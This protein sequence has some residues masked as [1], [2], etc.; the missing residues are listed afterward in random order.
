MKI[1]RKVSTKKHLK[2][3]VFAIVLSLAILCSANICQTEAISA[4]QSEQ[5]S[6][7]A[8]IQETADGLRGLVDSSETYVLLDEEML[9]AGSSVSD[10]IAMALAFSGEEE[11]YDVYLERLEQ[12]VTVAYEEQNCLD[13]VEATPYHR[14]TLTVLALGG[15]PLAFGTDANQEN[16]NL[17]ADGT[18]YFKGDSLG[19]QGLS[20]YI[21]ALLA[22]DAMAYEVPEDATYTRENIIAEILKAQSAEG[23]FSQNGYGADVDITAMAL[24]ALAPYQDRKEVNSAIEKALDYLSEEMTPYGTFVSGSAESCES[25]AQVIL[26]M[27]ALDLDVETDV[28]FQKNGMTP[29]EGIKVFRL[30]D[31]TYVHTLEEEEGNLIATEQALLALEAVRARQM[32]DRWIL[33]FR[34]YDS[35]ESVH[36]TATGYA[37]II[38]WAV[39][40]VLASG[41]GIMITRKKRRER[42]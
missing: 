36:I 24:Q 25:T 41:I 6:L 39:V 26:A 11:A 18:Y 15:D 16:I 1:S 3:I 13:A 10:W 21:Y 8:M 27:C 35:P 23:G 38:I 37:G 7:D 32:E 20:G 42:V 19:A 17:V 30:S 33:D 29:W 2:N 40:I 22:L 5:T 34:D 4:S 31:G 12:Y 28:R 9:K 14:T